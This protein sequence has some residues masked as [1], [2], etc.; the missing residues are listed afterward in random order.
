MSAALS[1]PPCRLPPEAEALR[2]QVRE[3]L[4]EALSGLAASQRAKSWLGF[5]LAFTKKLAARGWIGMTWPKQYGGG[6]L[7]AFARHVVVEELVASGAPVMAHWIA[8]R[9]S[10]PLILRYGTEAQKQKYLAPITRGESCFAIGMSEPDSGSDLASVRSRAVKVIGGWVL[11]GTKVW[12]SNAHRCQAMI[13]LIRTGSVESRQ[14]GLTQF[15]VDMPTAG[16]KVNPIIDMTAEHHFNEVVFEDC[17]LADEQLLGGEGNGWAQV[18][19]ELALE[20]SGPERFMSSMPLLAEFVRQLGAAPEASAAA[21]AGRLFARHAV[22]RQ[23]SVSIAGQIDRR[24]DPQLEA[25]C[26]KDLGG[27][28]EQAVPDVVHA[29]LDEQPLT[30]AGVS[31]YA[32]LLASVTEM[33]PSFTLRGGTREVLRSIIARGVGLR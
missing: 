13:A 22:L 11:N 31:E 24:Q 25:A 9:Q 27:D 32:R 20:R 26:L 5:D 4:A 14:L 18:T 12:T 8:D 21:A 1:F 2:P 15:L 7:S 30:G 10:G 6:E 19:S 33:A 3:F 23:M 17:F 16:I 29:L 28:L